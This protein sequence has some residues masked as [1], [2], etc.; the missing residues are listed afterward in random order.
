MD[1]KGCA[2]PLW[3]TLITLMIAT[4]GCG[5]G[6]GSSDNP[7]NTNDPITNDNS[8]DNTSNDYSGSEGQAVVSDSNAKALAIGAASGVKQAVEEQGMRLP[9]QMSAQAS[10]LYS[11]PQQIQTMEF[12]EPTEE[13]QQQTTAALCPHGGVATIELI[14]LRG[15]TTINEFRFDSCSYGEGLYLYTF[16]GTGHTTTSESTIAFTTIMTGSLTSVDSS[17]R[18]I[19]QTISCD[20]SFSCSF[21]SDYTGF[22]GRLYR[23]TEVA[24]TEE[25][26]SAYSASGRIYDPNHGYID[27]T[28]EIPFTLDCPNDR[29]GT[30]R[31]SFVGAS[32]SSGTIEFISCTQYVVSTSIGT[33]NTYNW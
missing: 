27:V 22:D 17:T 32:Q 6:G 12:I 3:A 9:L 10:K 16:T 31:L 8:G 23:V 20:A 2:R 4:Q 21:S 7:A 24:V 5:G 30:G 19:N 25:G 28:T 15:D 18:T 26:G 13:M 29:P 11:A 33:S 1:I 14:E